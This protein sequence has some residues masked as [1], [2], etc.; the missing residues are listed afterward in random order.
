[1]ASI[2]HIINSII[3]WLTAMGSITIINSNTIHWRYQS[4][5]R[6]IILIL[7]LSI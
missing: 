2:I 5:A 4:Q 3:T 1:M 7:N 6:V